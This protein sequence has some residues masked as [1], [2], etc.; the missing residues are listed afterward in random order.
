MEVTLHGLE[1][2]FAI[3]TGT[4]E[5]FIHHLRWWGIERGD[6]KPRVLASEHDFGLK[7]HPPG[8]G[9][10]G[11]GIRELLLQAAADGRAGAMRG[12]HARALLVQTTSLLHDGGSVAEHNRV[13]A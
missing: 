10:R 13:A 1:I 7:H 6:N 3:A 12:R 4:V 9:P 5:V 8:L 11:S 2:I